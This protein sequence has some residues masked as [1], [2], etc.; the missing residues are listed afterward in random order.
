MEGIPYYAYWAALLDPRTKVKTSRVLL[1]RE[2]GLV[3]KDIQDT[4]F[5]IAES[6]ASSEAPSAGEASNGN[7]DLVSS[8]VKHRG[9][10][11]LHCS[12]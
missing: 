3:W 5:S 12:S 1:Q 8:T 4:V 11:R 2:R 10:K 7:E 6:H 9:K